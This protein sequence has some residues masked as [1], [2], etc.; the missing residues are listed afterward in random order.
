MLQCFSHV[1]RPFQNY[2][3]STGKSAGEMNTGATRGKYLLYLVCTGTQLLIVIIDA[4]WN[5][6]VCFYEVSYASARSLRMRRSQATFHI[7]CPWTVSITCFALVKINKAEFAKSASTMICKI[8]LC[9][10]LK[11]IG[12]LTALVFFS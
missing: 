5:V 10:H 4:T 1:L 9:S 6:N 8:R 12:I 3:S 11:S 2:F 7:L